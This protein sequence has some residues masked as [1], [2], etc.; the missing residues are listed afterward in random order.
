MPAPIAIWYCLLKVSAEISSCGVA[1]QPLHLGTNLTA[2]AQPGV[3][4]VREPCSARALLVA[5]NG[6][7]RPLR[8]EPRGPVHEPRP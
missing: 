3:V 6:L 2:N 7:V 5:L 4:T 1:H 8:V